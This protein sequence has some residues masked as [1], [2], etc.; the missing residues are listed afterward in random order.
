[1][2]SK[3]EQLVQDF[4][5]H[6]RRMMDYKSALD[7][8]DWDAQTH[9]PSKGVRGRASA[10]GTLAAERFR[11]SVSEQM[12]HYL[13]QLEGRTD[14][15]PVTAKMVALCRKDYDRNQKIPAERFEAYTALTTTAEHVWQQAREQDDFASFAPYLQQIVEMK[16]EFINYWGFHDHPYNALLDEYEP[17]LS[18]AVLDP[19]FAEF[20]DETVELLRKIESG[21]KQDTSFLLRYFDPVK[22]KQFSEFILGQLGYDHEA[23]Q[24]DVTA[25]PFCTTIAP[26]DVRITT[27]YL[28]NF[29]NSA[30]F[31]T[32]HECGHALYEQNIDPALAGTNL[33]EGTSMGI[34]ESQSRFWENVVGRSYA[35]WERYYDDLQQLFPESLGD[36]TRDQFY[37]GISAVEP[38]L[39]RVEADEV[40]Y[41]L[42]I[43]IRYEIEKGLISGDMQ[44]ADLPAI[45]RSKMQEYL[46]TSPST[47]RDG[48]LQDVHWSA[49]SFGYFPSYALGNLN[50]AQ[51]TQALRRDLPDFD[52][53][54]R[55]GDFTPIRSWLVEHIY[56]YGKMLTPL[57]VMQSATGEPLNARY[58][59]DYF[60]TKFG[61]L[62]HF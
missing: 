26:G 32:I 18:V 27:R 38:S 23:G 4:R 15:D 58:Q 45:W 25:H 42:H 39:I 13:E 61:P 2:T 62:Y 5:T 40:T 10:S 16:R 44:V 34:H 48:V 41:N 56:R 17:G 24:L 60:K 21:P 30:I 28:P 36:V 51:L 19:L 11:L 43:M 20:R 52:G 7:L 57:E 6:V 12:G 22:Q 46:G 29:F 50:G 1:M 35:F 14:L 33:Y 9:M 3:D 49:G 59:L 31:G 47:D 53:M 37:A 8:L 55:R 54:V